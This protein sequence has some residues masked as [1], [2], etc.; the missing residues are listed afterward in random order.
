MTFTLKSKELDN[1]YYI[2]IEQDKFSSALRVNMYDKFGRI[3][4]SNIYGDMD[5]AKRCFYSYSSQAK[6]F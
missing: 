3:E 4:R 6:K 2:N 5:K 1:G